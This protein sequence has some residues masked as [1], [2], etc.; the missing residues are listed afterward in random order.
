MPF[1]PGEVVVIGSA[2]FAPDPLADL[3][4]GFENFQ[5]RG[6][7]PLMARPQIRDQPVQSDG[8]SDDDKVMSAGQGH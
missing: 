8:K 1:L 3:E 6:P 4:M 2:K 5:P 7:Q